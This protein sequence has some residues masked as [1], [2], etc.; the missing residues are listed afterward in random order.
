MVTKYVF[1]ADNDFKLL[2]C[3]LICQ[4]Y[5]TDGEHHL[6][7]FSPPVEDIWHLYPWASRTMLP[8]VHK[9]GHSWLEKHGQLRNRLHAILDAVE[10]VCEGADEIVL[11]T[12]QIYS[13]R[14]NYLINSLRRK[15]PDAKLVVRLIPDG[16]RN[17]KI[18]RLSGI[19]SLAPVVNRLKWIFDPRLNYY[20][21]S[22]DRLGS[23][24]EI[25]DRIYLPRG[26][27]HQYQNDKVHWVDMPTRTQ[28]DRPATALVLG[29]ALAEQGRCS[30]AEMAH[31][32]EGIY[33]Y[34]QTLGI[35]EV[36]YKRHPAEH[37]DRM[38]LFTPG[39]KILETT[40][41][42]ERLLT[43]ND[44]G[45][46]VS[47]CSTAL[48]TAKL[49]MPDLLVT[50]CGLEVIERRSRQGAGIQNFRTAAGQLGIN[51]ISADEAIHSKRKAA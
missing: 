13:E 45:Y 44:I 17:L 16:T 42:V 2:L 20:G 3:E 5:C 28:S 32:A 40:K 50:A 8:W 33:Q 19:R 37:P 1:V 12:Y 48:I 36:W 43:E 4:Q 34:L 29:T 15:F 26:F 10:K 7:S 25:V 31:V 18:R 9:N 27:P 49:M 41:G 46:V 22:G 47:Q 23:D 14:T 51:I 30:R 24:A 6:V 35:H 38:E 21:Y 11:H 39:Y